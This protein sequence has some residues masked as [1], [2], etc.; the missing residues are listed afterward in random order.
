MQ[1]SYFVTHSRNRI[2]FELQTTRLGDCKPTL[3]FLIDNNF[4]LLCTVG[5][6]TLYIVYVHIQ[7]H[8]TLHER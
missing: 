3:F 4:I 1:M 8:D 6:T 2:R 7:L 5:F